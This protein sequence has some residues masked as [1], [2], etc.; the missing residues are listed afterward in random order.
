[1]Q[2]RQFPWEY[3]MDAKDCGPA[4]IK[5]IAKYY[6]KYYSLQY[7]RDLCGIT[8]E[9]VSFLDISYAAEKIGLRTVAVKA[10]MEN[11]T[12]RI[13]LPC[14][15]H[16][17]QHHFVVVYKTKKGKIYV[18]DPAKG[19]L[20]YPEE[21]FKDRWYKEGEEFG[22]LMVLEP[23][24]NFKQIEAHE[25]IERFKSIRHIVRYH[26]DSYRT[27]S[28]TSVYL[29]VCNRYR[30]IYSGYIF[31]LY[32]ANRQYCSFTQ[33]NTVQCIKRLGIAACFYPCQYLSHIGLSDQTDEAT[34]DFL[35]K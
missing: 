13:P 22:M 32:D 19:L 12:N 27:A 28:R 20:S 1:M 31:H 6:G 29:K 14:I 24:A 35:R 17:D 18:S 26:A 21:D 5:M 10:T 34:G 33:Y 11:L 2:T 3:Q 23:M 7:L 9:G 15:I 4:C 25:R 8:R 30:Y 16:W